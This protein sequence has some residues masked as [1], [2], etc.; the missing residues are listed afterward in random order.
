MVVGHVRHGL[1]R[2]GLVPVAVVALA[3][4]GCGGED[5]AEPQ[6]V[7]TAAG[8]EE[9]SSADVDFATHMIQHHAQAMQMVVTAQGRRDLDPALEG[10]MEQIRSTQVPEVEI[11]TDWLEAWGQEVPETAMDHANAGHD[12]SEPSTMEDMAGDLPGMMTAEELRAL[13]EARGPAF[14]E[15]WLT[16]M[17]EHHEGAVEMASAQVEEGHNAEAVALAE[18]IVESQS[19]EITTM[20]EMLTRPG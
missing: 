8:G 14:E 9:Y 10:L 5:S 1:R 11:M 18:D 12:L 20:E 16:M 17:I 6:P 2:V 13:A 4:G 15:M 7:S 3:I 19:D